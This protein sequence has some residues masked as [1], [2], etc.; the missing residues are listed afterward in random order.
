MPRRG[1]PH[2]FG[3]QIIHTE[4]DCDV[5]ELPTGYLIALDKGAWLEEDSAGFVRSIDPPQNSLARPPSS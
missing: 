1:P 3:W 2:S 5:W 4:A